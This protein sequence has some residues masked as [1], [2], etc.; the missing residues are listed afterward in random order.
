MEELARNN[1]E[2]AQALSTVKKQ[3]EVAIDGL[4]N[5]SISYDPY[6]I[7][8]KCLKEIEDLGQK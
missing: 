6:D 3:L 4:K 2:L 7:A 5:I 1:I 8:E